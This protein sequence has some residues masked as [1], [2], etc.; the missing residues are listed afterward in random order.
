MS[1]ATI[2]G[3]IAGLAGAIEVSG[4]HHFMRIGITTNFGYIG[5]GVGMLAGLSAL[6]AIPSALFF[7]ILLNGGEQMH[8]ATGLPLVT[9]NTI[10]GMIIITVLLREILSRRVPK[11]RFGNKPQGK[12]VYHNCL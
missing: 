12:K 8:L 2:S 7:G 6:W 3:A 5:V 10:V 11:A 4:V 1:A 9:V